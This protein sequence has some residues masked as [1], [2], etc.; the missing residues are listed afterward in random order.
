MGGLPDETVVE[1]DAGRLI[2]RVSPLLNGACIED[3]N[4]EIYGGLY[5]QMIFGESFQEPARP[6]PIKGF[7][8][9]G[10]GWR[11]T[12]GELAADG[13]EGPKLIS[14][15]PVVAVGEVGI[16]V[17]LPGHREGNAGLIL[18]V[19]E[20]GV[21][22]D[23]FTGYEISLES[24][25]RLTLGRHRQNWELIRYVPCDV[26]ADRWVA[27]VVRLRQN[28]FEVLVD[29]RSVAT[30]EDTEH[31]LERGARRPAGPGSV[32]RG[33]RNLPGQDG[34]FGRD[35]FPSFEPAA[36][37]TF[38]EGEPAGCGGAAL[39]A[40]ARPAASSP[41]LKRKRPSR[42]GRASG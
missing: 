20:P 8:A 15:G 35:A 2:H 7:T 24:R 31:P 40:G 1:V 29:G 4:H 32:P 26:S 39:R 13:G 27:L 17:F 22:A 23:K 12:E 18:K 21:G 41:R 28:G 9:Y 30:Y 16:E 34:R 37:D 6:L 33:F 25:G 42:A 11:P 10:G 14:D 38:G 36:S 3:V 19:R 5:S